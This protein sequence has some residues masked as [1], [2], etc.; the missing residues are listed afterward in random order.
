[1]GMV[2]G[3]ERSLMNS[4]SKKVVYLTAEVYN[5]KKKKVPKFK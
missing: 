3:G 5:K 1:M 4:I 2:F